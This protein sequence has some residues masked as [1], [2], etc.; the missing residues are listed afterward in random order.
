M[1]LTL[2][3]ATALA[4][5]L[6]TQQA[7]A[8]QP[9]D[10]PSADAEDSSRSPE[11]DDVRQILTVRQDTPAAGGSCS[12][13]PKAALDRTVSATIKAV[14]NSDANAF[15]NLIGPDGV[16]LS[17]AISHDKLARD[18]AAKT[19][20]Y[21]DLFSCAGKA[22][23]LHGKFHDGPTDTQYD[24]KNKRA[25]V[26]INANTNDELDLS[27]KWGAACRWELTA[28]AIP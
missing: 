25:A 1:R 5:L 17:G 21:C 14:S 24:A 3:A 28:I 12:T 26:F 4:G 22:G 27:Y 2:L 6:M 19:G 7:C 23:N 13:D 15:L 20:R 16:D 9:A 18:F 8:R 10:K 11:R